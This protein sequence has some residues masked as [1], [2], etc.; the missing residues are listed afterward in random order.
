MLPLIAFVWTSFFL[1]SRDKNWNSTN[2]HIFLVSVR[3]IGKSK[4]SKAGWPAWD[5]DNAVCCR[6]PSFYIGDE[7]FLQFKPSTDWKRTTS[8]WRAICFTQSAL[9]CMWIL[10]KNTLTETSRTMFGHYLTTEAQPSWHIN[11]NITHND[12]IYNLN[13]NEC[14][15]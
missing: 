6:F 8:L 3:E 14:L 1:F 2:T 7:S 9:M 10:S 15:W 11:L 4:I 5:P 12:N 13:F